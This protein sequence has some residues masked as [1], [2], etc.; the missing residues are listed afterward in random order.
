MGILDIGIQVVMTK[1]AK[2]GMCMR[3]HRN[4]KYEQ[5]VIGVMLGVENAYTICR[6]EG[7]S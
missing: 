6:C 3:T 4:N 2:C 7:K 1:N 5:E